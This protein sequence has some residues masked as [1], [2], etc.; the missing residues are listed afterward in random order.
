MLLVNGKWDHEIEHD[1]ARKN[2]GGK[3]AVSEHELTKVNLVCFNQ[4][5]FSTPCASFAQPTRNS[6]CGGTGQVFS[7]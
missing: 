5:L 3:R 2:Q 1:V 6:F 4:S 7:A